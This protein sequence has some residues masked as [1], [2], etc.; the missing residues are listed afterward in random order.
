MDW[1]RHYHGLCKDEKLTA[2]AMSAGVSHCVAVAAW[3]YVLEHASAAKRRGDVTECHARHCAIALRIE[4]DE[5]DRILRAFSSEGLIENGFVANWEKRQ[6]ASDSSAERTKKW[7]EK[8]KLAEAGE[9]LGTSPKRK[10]TKR[11]VTGTS[12][13]APEQNRTEQKEDRGTASK[14]VRTLDELVLDEELISLAKAE[15]RDAA[16]E[17]EK[18]RDSCVAKGREYKDYRA[19]FRTWLRS[20]YGREPATAPGQS[21]PGLKI[22]SGYGFGLA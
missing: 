4:V 15:R 2:A 6:F 21:G 1:F 5:A 14:R 22:A 16:R 12:R 11:D 19:G 13:D 18:F 7:R 20:P 17:L 3:C 10:V 9:D 8:N